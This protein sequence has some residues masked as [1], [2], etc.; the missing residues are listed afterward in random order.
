MRKFPHVRF[1]F[2]FKFVISI[3]NWFFKLILFPMQNLNRAQILS[4]RLPSHSK[5][6]LEWLGPRIFF[7]ASLLSFFLALLCGGFSTRI[8]NNLHQ[9]RTVGMIW[10]KQTYKRKRHPLRSHFCPVPPLNRGSQ[11]TVLVAT[12]FHSWGTNG[13]VATNHSEY[14]NQ[15]VGGNPPYLSGVDGNRIVGTRSPEKWVFLRYC[16]FTSFLIIK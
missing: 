6:T 13:G 7:P 10:V 5:V 1:F 3:I 2:C 9:N 8:P 14:S 15:I 4:F 16:V 11:L 12:V